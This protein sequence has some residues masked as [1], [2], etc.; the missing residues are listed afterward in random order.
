MA[1]ALDVSPFN[2]HASYPRLPFGMGPRIIAY[3]S[4]PIEWH[5]RFVQEC[6]AANFQS[7]A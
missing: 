1:R 2:S 5:N 7:S 4:F 3:W 6:V